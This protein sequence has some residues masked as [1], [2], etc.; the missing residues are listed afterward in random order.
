MRSSKRFWT[1]QSWKS[2]AKGRHD[3]T[4]LGGLLLWASKCCLNSKLCSRIWRSAKASVIFL[5][6]TT[7]AH[8]VW[9]Y[10]APPT[11]TGKRRCGG[12]M[13]DR[14]K[15]SVQGG[16]TMT[17]HYYLKS[18]GLDSRNPV[19]KITLQNSR[20]SFG[21]ALLTSK[22]CELHSPSLLWKGMFQNCRKPEQLSKQP[23]AN[24]SYLEALPAWEQTYL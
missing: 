9:R 22:R 1:F 5:T 18:R 6:I 24:H 7:L 14:K 23:S 8:F 17:H 13:K 19:T 16:E 10:K 12:K 4:L 3:R 21:I 15:T 2:R 20:G 11:G